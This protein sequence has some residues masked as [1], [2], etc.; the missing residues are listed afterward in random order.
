MKKTI[1]YTVMVVLI[2]CTASYCA[3]INVPGGSIDIS[4]LVFLVS[5]M[6]D[7]PSGPAAACFEE[8][9]LNADESV[10]ISDLTYIV[11]YMFGSPNG[12][13]PLPCP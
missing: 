4:D 13:A 1:L 5:Y 8:A 3:V 9:D 7:D 12:P 11:D 6:F 10:D 2:C